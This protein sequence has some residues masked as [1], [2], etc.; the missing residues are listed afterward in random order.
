MK[1]TICSTVAFLS[2]CN[3]EHPTLEFQKPIPKYNNI[4]IKDYTFRNIVT[5]TGFDEDGAPYFSDEFYQKLRNEY[6]RVIK[7][8]K[9]RA[10]NLFWFDVT[11]E[12]KCST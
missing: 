12:I 2:N 6:D 8:D 1:Q 9:E 3:H 7:F 11:F 5:P 10:R 4:I